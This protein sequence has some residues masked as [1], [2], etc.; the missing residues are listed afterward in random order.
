VAWTLATSP[1]PG[2]ASA[3]LGQPAAWSVPASFL[4][5]VV[6]SRLTRD[7][8]PAHAGRFMVRLH[9]PEAVELQR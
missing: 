7:S 8:V 6:V 1:S 2:W 5:M 4:T 9:T 3:M